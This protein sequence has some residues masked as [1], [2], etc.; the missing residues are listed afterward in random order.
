MHDKQTNKKKQLNK[1]EMQIVAMKNEMVYHH[2]HLIQEAMMM[3]LA[4]TGSAG[5]F[6]N[7]TFATLA[8]L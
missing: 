7:Y 3:C 6:G 5:T 8:V 4:T 1:T 2:M